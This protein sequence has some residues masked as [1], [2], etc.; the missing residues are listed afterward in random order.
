MAIME[1]IGLWFQ[2]GLTIILSYQS[3]QNNPSWGAQSVVYM[4]DYELVIAAVQPA[5]E[6]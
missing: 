5:A 4:T 6:V 1:C 2:A 3:G